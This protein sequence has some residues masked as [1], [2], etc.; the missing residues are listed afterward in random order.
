M[1]SLWIIRHSGTFCTDTDAGITLR[2]Q[3]LWSEAKRDREEKHE[4]RVEAG[5]LSSSLYWVAQKWH[6]FVLQERHFN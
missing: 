5:R 2:K 6:C 4:G 1:S 3:R